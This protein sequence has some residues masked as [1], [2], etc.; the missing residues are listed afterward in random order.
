MLPATIDMKTELLKK[1]KIAGFTLLELLV[2]MVIIVIIGAISIPAFISIS[3]GHGMRST[4]SSVVNHVSLARQ[5][6][7]T[8][9]KKIEFHYSNSVSH[10]IFWIQDE[11]GIQISRVITNTPGI[12][13][14]DTGSVRFKTDGGVDGINASVEI[15]DETATKKI[16]IVALTGMISVE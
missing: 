13:F 1:D 15:K 12:T 6:A 10:S 8:H 16:K 4:V 7:I 11:N 3:R 9:R 14:G 5:W 2:V